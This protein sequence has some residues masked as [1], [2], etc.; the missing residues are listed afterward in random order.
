[1]TD[2]HRFVREHGPA[3]YGTAWR[4]LAHA[5]DAEDV[6][7]DVFLEAHRLHRKQA[8]RHWPALLRRMATCRALDRL[9]R[10]QPAKSLTG[11]RLVA[12]GGGPDMEASA[13]E[14]EERLLRALSRLPARAAEVFCLRRVPP[15]DLATVLKAMRAGRERFGAYRAVC[16]ETG[17]NVPSWKAVN[18]GQVWRKGNR[19]RVEVPRSLPPLRQP[20]AEPV[21]TAWW[22]KRCDETEFVPASVC[23]GAA[24]YRQAGLARG[25]ARQWEEL[26]RIRPDQDAAPS[27]VQAAKYLPELFG[28]P[29]PPVPSAQFTAELDR[30]P[31]DGPPGTV[32]VTATATSQLQANAYRRDRY[33]VDPL[34]GYVTLKRVIDDGPGDPP[35]NKPRVTYVMERLEQTPTGVW[36]PTLVRTTSAAGTQRSPELL[37]WFFLDFTADLPDRLFEPCDR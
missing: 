9:R 10:R 13:R 16:P 2:W 24:V 31:T 23:N 36:Y 8:V 17:G 34:R 22:L 1:L 32:L 25:A 4:I 20:P 7:Q 6:V 18:L 27:V 26:W 14:L 12:P 3:V 15:D 19:W 35:E 21:T 28:Y 37:T 11:L 30:A 33:W 29:T 5:A